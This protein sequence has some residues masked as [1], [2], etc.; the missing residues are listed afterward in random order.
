MRQH[1][2]TIGAWMSIRPRLLAALSIVIAVVAACGGKGS[3]Y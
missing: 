3:S 2:R 1:N